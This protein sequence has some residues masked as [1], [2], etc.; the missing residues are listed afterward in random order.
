VLLLPVKTIFV[1]G[2]IYSG[3]Y[4]MIYSLSLFL[5]SFWAK[6]AVYKSQLFTNLRGKAKNS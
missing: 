6:V 3:L 4:L 2:I 1:V 5:F